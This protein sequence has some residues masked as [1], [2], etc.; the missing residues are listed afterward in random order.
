MSSTNEIAVD[1]IPQLTAW[2]N[3]RIML[4]RWAPPALLLILGAVAWAVGRPVWYLVVLALLALLVSPLVFPQPLTAAEAQR[5]SAADGRAIIYWRPGCPFCLRL[6]ATLAGEARQAYWVDI[7]KD[8]EAA[9]AVRAVADGNETVPTV[10]L[11]GV[12]HVN[13]NPRW[14]LHQLR[15]E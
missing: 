14:L 1:T 7:W 8:P 2:R 5:R 15:A 9:A 13:P 10:I 12:P 6:R 3:V 4:R 11:A